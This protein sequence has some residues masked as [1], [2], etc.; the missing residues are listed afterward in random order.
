MTRPDA[1]AG[2]A[3]DALPAVVEGVPAAA[4]NGVLGGTAPEK[5]VVAAADAAELATDGSEP[6]PP[7][8]YSIYS[9]ADKWLIVA[10][11][12]AAGFYR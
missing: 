11:V 12:A 4:A 5:A 3:D 8:P 9:R 10:M 2:A 1:D 6:P 7:P